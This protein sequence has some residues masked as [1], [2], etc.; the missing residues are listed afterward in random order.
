MPEPEPP[1]TSDPEKPEQQSAF[2]NYYH[3]GQ[4]KFNRNFFVT[5]L[6]RFNRSVPVGEWMVIRTNNEQEYWASRIIK[7]DEEAVI[8]SVAV[9]E[10]WTDQTVRYY[11]ITE[12]FIQSIEG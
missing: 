7:V 1:E 5:E 9:G 6:M 12:I 2:S 3:R 8:F 4:V 10:I 11:Q